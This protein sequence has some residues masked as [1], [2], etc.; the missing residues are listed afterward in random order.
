MVLGR[1]ASGFV[2][3]LMQENAERDEEDLVANSARVDES[4]EP[5]QCEFDADCCPGFECGWVSQVSRV[6][7]VCVSTG[8]T[9]V[10]DGSE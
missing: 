5:R 8:Y 9:A 1:A 4:N 6:I 7:K 10:A 2:S 3:S